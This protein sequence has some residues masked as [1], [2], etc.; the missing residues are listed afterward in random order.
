M[1]TLYLDEAVLPVP[2]RSKEYFR[3]TARQFLLEEAPEHLQEPSR[4]DLVKLLDTGLPKRGIHVYPADK[5]TLGCR[6]GATGL[7]DD[8]AVNILLEKSVYNAVCSGPL[9]DT[10][11]RSTCGH[12]IIHALEHVDA[13]RKELASA[14]ELG[15][16]R[17]ARADLKPY[18]DPE[19]QA[20]CGAGCLLVPLE[21]LA[22]V[23]HLPERK[24]ASLYGVS[25][26]F[27]R[28]HRKRFNI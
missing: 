23:R 4:L 19:W 17:V 11:A 22:T 15:L 18:E 7:S 16:S 20:W 12:E 6:E 14:N 24:I 13:L 26:K 1:G 25:V 28:S 10:R 27:L 2:P 21:T 9:L 8:G 5:T 3:G